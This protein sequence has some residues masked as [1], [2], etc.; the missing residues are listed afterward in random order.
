MIIYGIHACKNAVQSRKGEILRVYVSKN[1]QVPEWLS[2]IPSKKISQIDELEF[3]KILPKDAVYQGVA[4]EVDSQV[5]CDI[6]D[7]VS[8]PKTCV[9][10]ILDNVTDPQNLGAII[11]TAATFGVMGIVL[12]ERSSC[13]V[14]GVVAKI[15]SGGLEHV[16]IFIVKNL[17]QAIEKI[18][19]YGFW[20]VSFCE[21]GE[22]FLH[23]IDLK[24]RTC[25][26]FGAEG[27]GIRRLQKEKSDFV[28]KLPTNPSF[29]TL[30][31]SASAAIAFYEAAKQNDFKLCE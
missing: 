15:A 9:I 12:S 31:V 28:A 30:N 27:D 21:R 23:D 1:K 13:K 19:S 7:L 3:K 20:V 6:T 14:T 4:V 2:E 8:A 5:Y 11:R 22:K 26:V 24:G 16:S 17:A 18:Q 29:P 10:A 25:L